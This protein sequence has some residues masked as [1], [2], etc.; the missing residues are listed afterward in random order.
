MEK[1]EVAFK[2]MQQLDSY[3]LKMHSITAA[4]FVRNTIGPF[5]KGNFTMDNADI[6]DKS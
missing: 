1:G 5:Q 2:C 3:V 4:A 6:T